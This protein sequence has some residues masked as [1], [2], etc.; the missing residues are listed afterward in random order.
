M[1]I[2]NSRY[3]YNL[4]REEESVKN[5]IS[6]WEENNFLGRLKNKDWSLWVDAFQP[7]IID[8][9]GWL[10]LPERMMDRIKGIETFTQEVK[11]ENF[12]DL[13]LIGMGGSSLAPEVVQKIFKDAPGFPKLTVCDSTHPQAVE[14]IRKRLDLKATLF[15]VSSKSGTTLETMSLFHFFWAEVEKEDAEPGKHFV[16]V[17]DYGTPLMREAQKKGFRKIFNPYSDVG[18]RF[19]AFTEFGLVPAS[20]IGVD[21][22]KLL[23]QDKNDPGL[24]LGAALGA[25]GEKRDKLYFVTSK[26]LK[27]FPDWIEQLVAESLGKDGKGIIPVIDEPWIDKGL[28]AKDRFYIFF[29]LDDEYKEIK[30]Y[31]EKTKQKEI[32]CIEIRLQDKYDLGKEM[33]NWEIG[34]AAAG[35]YLDIHPFNQPDVQAAKDFAKEA[36]K[37]ISQGKRDFKED[38]QTFSIEDEDSLKKAVLKELSGVIKGDYAAFQVYLAPSEK[39]KQK[40]QKIRKEIQKKRGIATTMGYGPRF[41]HSTGQLHK[42]GPDKGIFLQIVDSPQTDIKVP[43]KDYSFGSIIK[44]QSVGDFQALQQKNRR[45]LRIDLKS[46]TLKG[47]SKLAKM[48]KS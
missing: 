19:S 7:E 44:A 47:L 18:G 23:D 40:I 10:E 11:E 12:T 17:T 6:F 2:K 36:M 48:I 1:N 28:D 8:R 21:I 13:I 22:K 4:F 41:L 39:V 32:P 14:Q 35:S 26:S 33:F 24:F 16:A 9:L 15:L 46:Q 25:V 20:L 43:G 30:K 29:Y 37:N 38:V 34:V 45:I 31:I 5:L 3:S 27:A 42:G